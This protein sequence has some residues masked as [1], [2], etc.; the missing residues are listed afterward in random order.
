MSAEPMTNTVPRIT[1][2]QVDGA[3]S[4]Q[5]AVFREHWPN[6]IEVTE[7]NAFLLQKQMRAAGLMLDMFWLATCLLKAPALS[8]FQRVTVSACAEYRRWVN[9]GRVTAQAF[10]RLYCEQERRA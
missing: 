5:L 4:E 10:V 3:C 7:E 9:Y 2:E 8:E 6:G 1:A